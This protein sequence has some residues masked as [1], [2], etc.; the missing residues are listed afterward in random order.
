MKNIC[1]YYQVWYEDKRSVFEALKR[2]RKVYPTEELILVIAGLKQEEVNF[3][4]EAFTKNIAKA[5]NITTTDYITIEEFPEMNGNGKDL[6]CLENNYRDTWFNFSTLWLDKLIKLPSEKT[7]ILVACS[8][9]WIPLEQ[10]PFDYNTDMCGMITSASE[11]MNIESLMKYLPYKINQD[12]FIWWPA[13]GYYMDFK[14]FKEGYTE[15][16]KAYIKKIVEEV[17]PPN[18]GMYLDFICGIWGLYLFDSFKTQN[19]IMDY[20]TADHIIAKHG[21]KLEGDEQTVDEY[22]EEIYQKSPFISIHS[23][24]TFRNIPVSDEMKLLEIE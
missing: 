18:L 7:D 1:F 5:F 13:A 15:K 11:W 17:Y 10:I 4:H 23:Y 16:N 20:N 24:K 14:K 2:F 8:D 3:Y 22:P 9:D 12:E 19:Y 21:G 6:R